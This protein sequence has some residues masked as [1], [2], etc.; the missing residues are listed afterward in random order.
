MTL[1]AAYATTRTPQ[2]SWTFVDFLVMAGLVLLAV[3][4]VIKMLKR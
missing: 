1:A 4:R 3:S 2:A